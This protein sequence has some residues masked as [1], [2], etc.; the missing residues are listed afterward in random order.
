MP[1]GLFMFEAV[2]TQFEASFFRGVNEIAEPL[3]RAGLGNPT[4]LPAG[5]LVIETT[6]RKSGRKFNVPVL[7]LRVGELLVFATVRRDSQWV[8]NLVATPEVRFWLGGTLHAAT[9][10]V[11]TPAAAHTEEW[12]RA[13]ASLAHCLRSQ[14]RLFGV[15]FAILSPHP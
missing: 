10:Y 4:C 2:L 6:G 7:T 9:A 13:V 3:I 14:S 11:L 5:T 12:P 15:S 1:I 8:K